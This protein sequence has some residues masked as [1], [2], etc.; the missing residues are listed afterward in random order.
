MLDRVP[1]E[2]SAGERLGLELY[3]LIAA[4]A[5]SET[6]LQ[7]IG[8]RICEMLTSDPQSI[9]DIIPLPASGT[10]RLGFTVRVNDD[11][12]INLALAA[13]DPRTVGHDSPQSEG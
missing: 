10:H 1:S 8:G 7:H 4:S 9:I 13:N 6:A 12:R 5:S 11:V 3:E 2:G